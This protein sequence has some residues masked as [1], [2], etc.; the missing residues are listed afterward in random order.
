MDYRTEVLGAGGSRDAS[1]SLA[2]FL[3]RAP[4]TDAFLADLGLETAARA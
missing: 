3:G 1:I 4:S 2:V